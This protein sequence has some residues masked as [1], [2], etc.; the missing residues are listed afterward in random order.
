MVSAKCSKAFSTTPYVLS[1]A[2]KIH[3]ANEASDASKATVAVNQQ[4]F[5][6]LLLLTAAF[7]AN[8]QLP[9]VNTQSVTAEWPSGQAWK[10]QKLLMNKFKRAVR[11]GK[12]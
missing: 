4:C 7:Q 9:L 3:D 2:G 8:S 12:Q 11:I 1:T 10:I 6:L 5:S